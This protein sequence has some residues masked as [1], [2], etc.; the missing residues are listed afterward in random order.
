MLEQLILADIPKE[1]IVMVAVGGGLSVAVI[2]MVISAAQ[3]MFET[4]QREQTRREVSAYIAEGSMSPDEGE[5]I[6]NAGAKSKRS[7]WR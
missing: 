4:R 1:A 2:S 5:R 6:L 3:S 7:C